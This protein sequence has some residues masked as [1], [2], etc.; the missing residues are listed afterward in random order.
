MVAVAVVKSPKI[1]ESEIET[2]S[3]SRNVAEEVL[4]QV[5]AAKEWTKSYTIKVNL[6]SNPKTPIALAMKFLPHLRESDLR[7]LSK[8]KDVSGVLAQQARRLAEAK[9]GS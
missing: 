5:A 4:R 2:I 6:T 8:S 3:K 9:S 7:K 1:Q